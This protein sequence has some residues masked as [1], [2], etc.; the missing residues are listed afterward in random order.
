MTHNISPIIE[1]VASGESNFSTLRS[2][3][4]VKSADGSLFCMAGGESVIFKI[5]IEGSVFALKCYAVDKKDLK[6]RYANLAVLSKRSDVIPSMTYLENELSIIDN[7]GVQRMVD[8]LVYRWVEGV[9]LLDAIEKCVGFYD[10]KALLKLCHSFIILSRKLLA[11]SLT[12]GDLKP[13]NIVVAENGDMYLIDYDM[14]FFDRL[15]CERVVRTQWY[16]HPLAESWDEDYAVAVI[17]VS[18][19]LL[20]LD[21]LLFH[22][23]HNGENLIIDTHKITKSGM[24]NKEIHAMLVPYPNYMSLF[25]IISSSFHVKR[26]VAP[27][28]A[29]IFGEKPSCCKVIDNQGVLRR[30]VCQDGLYGFVDNEDKLVV[31]CCY[32]DATPFNDGVAGVCLNGSWYLFDAT[33]RLAVNDVYDEVG[34]S[35]SGMIPVSKNRRWY[36]I[37]AYTFERL[38]A[39]DYDYVYPFSCGFGLV[40]VKNSFYFVDVNGERSFGACTFQFARPFVNGYAI[41]AVEGYFVIDVYGRRVSQITVERILDYDGRFLY[42]RDKDYNVTSKVCEVEK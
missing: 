35:E 34:V 26:D 39:E 36:Y 20:S 22:K 7:Y 11:L 1:A 24:L 31:G 29:N 41:V 27:L 5:Q 9:T 33:G 37:S 30:I 12:H 6:E 23:Y 15:P 40:R 3:D 4:V 19:F 2:I 16:Q 32:G 38:G 21:P 10:T 17:V 25:E 42:Y 18:I 14:A 13:Q 28:L 8:V